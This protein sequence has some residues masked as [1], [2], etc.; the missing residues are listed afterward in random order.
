MAEILQFKIGGVGIAIKYEGA[1]VINWPHPFYEKF[2]SNNTRPQITLNVHCTALPKHSSQLIFDSKKEGYWKLYRN[3]PKYVIETFDTLT[4]MKNKVCFLE[5]DFSYGEVYI[6]PQSDQMHYPKKIRSRRPSWSLPFLLQPLGQ[7]L[8]VNFLAKGE[9]VM[10]HG[11][12][13]NDRGRGIAFVGESGAG[14]STM[15][16]LW[17]DQ[18]R[19]NILC[20]EHIIIKKEKGVF[21]LYGT[22]WPGMNM[23]VSSQSVPLKK[24][25]FIEHFSENKILGRAAANSLIPLLFLPF[26]DKERLNSALEFCEGL[27]KTIKCKKLGFVKD[28]SVVEFV[29]K[30]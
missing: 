27:F 12:G 2:L 5:P 20:D 1:R 29:R 26:W 13:I 24:L 28:K 22:P 11:L 6:D 3:G 16:N 17:G 14:K 10:A 8:L 15:A 25:F 9:G 23:D 7:L 19:A 30:G 21:R 18:I 4:R